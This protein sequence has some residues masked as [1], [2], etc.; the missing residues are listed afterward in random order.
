MTPA[1]DPLVISTMPMAT[2]YVWLQIMLVNDGV[3]MARDLYANFRMS[4]P[5]GNGEWALR[6]A[7]PRWEA[8]ESIGGWHAVAQDGFKL[9]P[10][11]GIST[12]SMTLYLKPPF[13]MDLWYQITLGCSGAPVQVFERTIPQTEIAE[14]HGRFMSSDRGKLAGRSLARSV[15]GLG[16]APNVKDAA[17]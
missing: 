11:A 3:V 9:A 16:D 5:G 6:K 2:A 1:H 4:G 15:F 12:I 8:H 7:A 13:T 17:D 14:A 10:S